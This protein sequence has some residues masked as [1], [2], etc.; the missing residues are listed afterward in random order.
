MLGQFPSLPSRC[1]LQRS[2]SCSVPGRRACL[3]HI[4]RRCSHTPG[5][6]TQ[7]RRPLHPSFSL[8]Q[9]AAPFPS[10]LKPRDMGTLLLLVLGYCISLSSFLHLTHNSFQNTWVWHRPPSRTL[11][12]HPLAQEVSFS[13]AFPSVFRQWL[14]FGEGEERE[15]SSFDIYGKG[16]NISGGVRSGRLMLNTGWAC[17]GFVMRWHP[18]LRVWALPRLV[19]QLC[20]EH[21]C[22]D[23][24]Y[25]SYPRFTAGEVWQREW[26]LSLNQTVCL[27]SRTRHNSSSKKKTFRNTDGY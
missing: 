25:S 24:R 10:F 19:Q 23:S 27:L 15:D 18:S 11:L 20:S 8:A 7:V 9:K 6:G 21:H 5:G 26:A 16:K 2:P 14:L 1:I 22:N 17:W 13:L 12:I 4:N 3:D